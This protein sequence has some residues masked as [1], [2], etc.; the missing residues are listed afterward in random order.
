MDTTWTRNLGIFSLL[1]LTVLAD[2]V[3]M[4]TLSFGTCAYLLPHALLPYVSARYCVGSRSG[5]QAGFCLFD[6]S[7]QCEETDLIRLRVALAARARFFNGDG[8][9]M[10]D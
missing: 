1:C 5:S 6:A 7:T 9:V 2:C 10:P 4:D 3:S 8:I